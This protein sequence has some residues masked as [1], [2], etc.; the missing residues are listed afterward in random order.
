MP[1]RPCCTPCGQVLA[2]PEYFAFFVSEKIREPLLTTRFAADA[3]A[4]KTFADI[5][6]VD[7]VRHSGAMQ[8]TTCNIAT[9]DGVRRRARHYRAAWDTV[10]RGIPT[11]YCGIP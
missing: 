7:D 6:T 3:D 8:Q 9:L 11:V 10:P 1:C 5:A 4:S 2:K